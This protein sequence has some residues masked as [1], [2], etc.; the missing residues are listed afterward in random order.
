M[1]NVIIIGAG[2]GGLE[3]GYILAKHGLKVTVLE[4]GGQ[5]GGCL[6][7]FRRMGR[8]FDAGFHYVGGLGE[9]QSLYPLFKYFNLLDLP[10]KRLDEDCFDEVHIDGAGSFPFA[11]GHSRFVER[12]AEKFP[13]S[14]DELKTYASFLKGVGDHIYDS[15][16]SPSE[17]F[18]K[19]AYDF[20]KGTISDPLLRKVLSGTSLKLEL[21]AD[22][23]PLYIFAQINNSFIQSAWRLEGGGGQIAARLADQIKAFGGEIRTNAKVARLVEDGGCISRVEL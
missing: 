13:G 10:W 8:L 17:N 2:L 4:Q 21:N 15:F 16:N 14:K 3:V 7:T 11:N 22:S 6:Q 20:L 18:S 19:S 5:I 1:D 23:L 9:G 12:M